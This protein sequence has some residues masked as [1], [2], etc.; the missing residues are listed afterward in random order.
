M[1][2]KAPIDELVDASINQTF[3]R[4]IYTALCTFSSVAVVYIVGMIYDLPTVTTF[5]LPM[6]VGIACGCYSSVFIAGPLYAWW[7]NHKLAKHEVKAN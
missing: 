6:M 4:S 2:P 3:T 5:A 1:G 7:Q